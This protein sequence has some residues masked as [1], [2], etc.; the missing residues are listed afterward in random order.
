MVDERDSHKTAFLT[1]YGLF[2]HVRMAHGLC[3]A[4]ATF[5]KVMNL[6]LRGLA[7]NKV[8]VYLDD[9]IVL[10]RSFEESLENL[11]IV[12]QRFAVHNLKL[13]PMKCSLFST[14]VHFRGLKVSREG[15]SVTND[16]IQSV[17][18]WPRPKNALHVSKFTGFV[19]YHREFIQG[20]SEKNETALCINKAK[21]TIRMDQVM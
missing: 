14:E 3:N 8:L 7:W 5:Q 11:E 9:V 17:L 20:L 21:G 10:G 6:V 13:K 2:E 18:N 1:K 15:V 16:H 19:N 4:P 12:L